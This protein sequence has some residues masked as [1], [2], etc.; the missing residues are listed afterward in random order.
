MKK[1][2]SDILYQEESK[3]KDL[4]LRKTTRLRIFETVTFVLGMMI[5]SNFFPTGSTVFKVFAVAIA[6]AV[7]ALSPFLYRAILRPTYTLTKTHL[8]VKMSNN[9]T[10]YPLHEVEQI[11]EGR[12]IYRLSGQ[13]Q[14]LMVSREFIAKLE[15]RLFLLKK[16]GKRR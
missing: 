9:E 14:S 16:L 10:S 13:R 7:V 1:E 11:S 8:I 3:Y 12:H 5:A 2:N 6:I 15:E 4:L